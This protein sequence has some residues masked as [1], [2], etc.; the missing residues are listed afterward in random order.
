MFRPKI[1]EHFFLNNSPWLRIIEMDHLLCANSP[2]SL[3]IKTG[4]PTYF[5]Y[6]PRSTW[7]HWGLLT[8]LYNILGC[9]FYSS[10]LSLVMVDRI[11]ILCLVIIIK[12][13]VWTTIH[14]F[15]L[16]ETMKQWYALYV[17][18]YSYHKIM[19]ITGSGD[20]LAPVWCQAS[21]R[22]NDIW[23]SKR[24]GRLL[25]STDPAVTL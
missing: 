18:L 15:G 25:W 22:T 10:P 13:E 9:V 12:W 23:W 14:C 1:C 2:G 20:G 21:T 4:R 7:N 11:Y 19:V 16:G 5:V 6:R 8:P 24:L 17:S 3:D